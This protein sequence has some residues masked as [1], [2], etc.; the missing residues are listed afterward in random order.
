M[1]SSRTVLLILVTGLAI[2][3]PL[4]VGCRGWTMDYGNPAAQF[5]A[6]D[7]A[8]LAPDYLGRK[9]SVRGEVTTVETSDPARCTVRL[10]HGV[11]ADFGTFKAAAEACPVG[12][13]VHLDGIVRAVDV[14]GIIL[15]PA[16]GRDPQALF[17]PLHP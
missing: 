11:V 17:D 6:R 8:I 16:F 10:Q 1:T 14:S 4:L 13:I 5:E 12:E 3:L 9:V 2:L 7:A 15:A